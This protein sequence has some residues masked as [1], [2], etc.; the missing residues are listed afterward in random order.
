MAYDP[1]TFVEVVE[2]AETGRFRVTVHPSDLYPKTIA[3]IQ[4][5]LTGSQMNSAEGPMLSACQRVPAGDWELA[6][7]PRGAFDAGDPR[8]AGRAI[9]LDTALGLF[10]RSIRLAMAGKDYDTTITRD[11]NY[12][13]R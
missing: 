3:R 11:D 13:L 1:L 10:M 4:E 12:K 6:L 5:M 7:T 9:A 8:L 2:D